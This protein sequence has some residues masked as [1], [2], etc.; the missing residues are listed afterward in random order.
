M[1]Q[2]STFV[3]AFLRTVRLPVIP[4]V[5]HALIRTL[6]EDDVS[7][8]Q[9]CNLV[10]MD[11]VITAKVMRAANAAAIGSSRR[12]NTLDAALTMIGTS[13]VRMLALTAC[14][15][16][17][18][19]E[20]PGISSADTWKRTMRCAGYARWLATE[21]GLDSQEAWLAGMMLTLGELIILQHRPDVLSSIK[22]APVVPG[23]RWHSE[24]SV[25][26]FTEADVAAEL[27]RRWHFPDRMVNTLQL[28]AEPM[29]TKKFDRLSGVLHLSCMLA[30]MP[31]SEPKHLNALPAKVF[32]SLGLTHQ[33]L[34]GKIPADDTFADLADI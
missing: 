8:E 22:R 7:I 23:Q 9:V 13:Q 28:A 4:E 20:V 32:N 12:L 34:Q 18:F 26:G 16:I 5:A 6:K 3:A 21:A 1:D 25:L 30:D 33:A 31:P 19:P 27:T 11:A 14:M 17:A 10:A 15:N 24:M 29:A 2:R